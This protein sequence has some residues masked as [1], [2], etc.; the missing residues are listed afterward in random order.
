MDTLELESG[1]LDIFVESSEPP[2]VRLE[3]RPDLLFG[4][5][6]QAQLIFVSPDV[7]TI[8]N[9]AVVEFN[10]ALRSYRSV[11]YDTGQNA[12]MINEPGI[13]YATWWVATQDLASDIPPYISFTVR[14]GGSDIASG[15]A[16]SVAP[17]F[18]VQVNGSALFD[19]FP[20]MQVQLANTSGHDVNLAFAAQMANMIVMRIGLL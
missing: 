20:G 12:F 2:R 13:Y 7:V 11:F 8:P 16:G 17:D 19:G 3:V 18:P 4:A 1:S 6:A 5:G 9:G 14:A 10:S 15:T